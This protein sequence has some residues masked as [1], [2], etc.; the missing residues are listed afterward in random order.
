MTLSAWLGSDKYQLLT[1]SCDA[2]MIRTYWFESWSRPDVTNGETEAELIRSPRLEM[3]VC[4]R[5]GVWGCDCS[6]IRVGVEMWEVLCL[7]V[8]V[9][10]LCEGVGWWLYWTEGV[11]VRA[12]DMKV[13]VWQIRVDCGGVVWI[14]FR[15][16]DWACDTQSS[17]WDTITKLEYKI[18]RTKTYIHVLP[19]YCERKNIYYHY[20]S[21]WMKRGLK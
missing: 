6:A 15:V 11:G 2:T 4:G 1:H 13:W 3:C 7:K 20:S 18:S 10:G 5:A 21:L 9:W 17:I 19:L 14:R 8:L 12:V 16:G